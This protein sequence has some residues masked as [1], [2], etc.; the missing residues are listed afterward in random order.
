MKLAIVLFNLGGPDSLEAV[1]PFLRNL[2]GD[3]AILSVP[4]IARWPLARFL[5]RRRA[6]VAREIYGQLGGSSP[7]VRETQAQARALDKLLVTRSIEAR[8]FIAMRC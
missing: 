5:A 6:P 4:G 2:F 3:P 7:I 1:E 8:S